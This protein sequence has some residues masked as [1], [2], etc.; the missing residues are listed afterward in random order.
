MSRVKSKA[1]YRNR[2]Y[3]RTQVDETTAISR[4]NLGNFCLVDYIESEG[5]HE[6]RNLF[7]VRIFVQ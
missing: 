5:K 4:F 3:V 7:C 1:Q 2:K 6:G